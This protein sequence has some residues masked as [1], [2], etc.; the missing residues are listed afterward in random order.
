MGRTHSRSARE[1]RFEEDG[2]THRR[3][4]ECVRC[5]T[6]FAPTERQRALARRRSLEKRGRERALYEVARRR[7]RDRLE[8]ADEHALVERQIE[9]AD[10][11]LRSLRAARENAAA[12]GQLARLLELRSAGRS[13]SEALE[14]TERTSAFDLSL[15]SPAKSADRRRY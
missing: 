9:I 2:Q 14:E 8:R 12:D 13:L 11:Q 4:C 6:G 5:E 7:E 3:D 15:R 10:G 1:S